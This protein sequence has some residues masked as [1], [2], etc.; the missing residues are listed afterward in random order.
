LALRATLVAITLPVVVFLCHWYAALPQR[1][2]G[3]T[4]SIEYLGKNG[5]FPPWLQVKGLAPEPQ[6][7]RDT[8]YMRFSDDLVFVCGRGGGFER[9]VGWRLRWCGFPSSR[10]FEGVC[11]S[12][13]ALAW[14]FGQLSVCLD[15]CG[16]SLF[17]LV[18]LGLCV[19]S[20]VGWLVL[21]CYIL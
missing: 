9:V 16:V 17:C 13:G 20:G 18:L 21:I 1:V 15:S 11:L 3:L 5:E 7:K 6:L 2:P 12:A 14:L 10:T 8:R 19:F 4:E